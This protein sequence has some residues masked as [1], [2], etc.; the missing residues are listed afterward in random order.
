MTEEQKR[1]ILRRDYS[2]SFITDQK[3]GKK[4]FWGDVEVALNAYESRVKELGLE[5]GE[6]KFKFEMAKEVI[7][8]KSARVKE[9][10][11]AITRYQQGRT[12]LMPKELTAE[13]GAKGLLMGEFFEVVRL[14]CPHCDEEGEDC[15]CC[16]GEAAYTYRIPISW[17]TIKE[18]Y[19]MC[20]SNLS[21]RV[22][23]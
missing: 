1:Y 23:K 14:E 6:L 18:I 13:N 22:S 16:E 12:V 20:V 2:D 3:L 21:V 5:M 9:L 7:D 8:E 10:E 17:P 19:S 15:G 4:F 11:Q